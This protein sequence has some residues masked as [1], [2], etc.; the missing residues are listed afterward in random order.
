MTAVATA[1]RRLGGAT[2]WENVSVTAMTRMICSTVMAARK[3]FTT[4]AAHTWSKI[5]PKTV[6]GSESLPTFRLPSLAVMNHGYAKSAGHLQ[7]PVS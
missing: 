7:D 5:P 1:V 4:I 2:M 6:V 3:H